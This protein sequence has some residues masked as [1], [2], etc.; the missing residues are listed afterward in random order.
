MNITKPEI[1]HIVDQFTI[2]NMPQDLAMFFIT[3]DIEYDDIF[4]DDW[5]TPVK[6]YRYVFSYIYAYVKNKIDRGELELAVRDVFTKIPCYNYNKKLV[7]N[8]IAVRDG[9]AIT[10]LKGTMMYLYRDNDLDGI[11]H[12]INVVMNNANFSP[13]IIYNI[14]MEEPELCHQ[15]ILSNMIS[16]DYFTTD[17]IFELLLQRAK[18]TTIGTIRELVLELFNNKDAL[19]SFA[20]VVFSQYS[21]R[22]YKKGDSIKVDVK[23]LAKG[24]RKEHI[25]NLRDFMKEI[26]WIDAEIDFFD[27]LEETK[28]KYARAKDMYLAGIYDTYSRWF[29]SKY[30]EDTAIANMLWNGYEEDLNEMQLDIEACNAISRDALNLLYIG[31]S[32][33]LEGYELFL[34]LFNINRFHLSMHRNT[35]TIREIIVDA[36]NENVL[37]V[38]LALD[39]NFYIFLVFN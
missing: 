15:Y 28:M 1:E 4:Y 36:L 29:G 34:K 31:D 20:A 7:E 13:F 16:G 11:N 35:D 2:K 32:R 30:R 6:F 27:F 3:Q 19:L 17:Q 12:L 37:P 22:T 24:E 33:M 18:V 14:M 21:I 38:N 9:F 5:R 8:G 25:D 39:L 10:L 26:I 23:C